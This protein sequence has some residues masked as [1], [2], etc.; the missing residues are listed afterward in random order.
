MRHLL[1]DTWPLIAESEALLSSQGRCYA[2][3]QTAFTM[4]ASLRCTKLDLAHSFQWAGVLLEIH[5][6]K[7]KLRRI[8][9]KKTAQYRVLIVHAEVTLLEACVGQLAVNTAFEESLVRVL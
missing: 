3:A 6:R 7:L 5:S 1:S 9:A 2:V 4:I 8:D